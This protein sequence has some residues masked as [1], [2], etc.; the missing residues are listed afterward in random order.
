[1]IDHDELRH[2]LV[3]LGIEMSDARL[4]DIVALL[5]RDHD[6]SIDYTEFAR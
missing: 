6:G 3:S 2:G 4:A 5:D 1:M